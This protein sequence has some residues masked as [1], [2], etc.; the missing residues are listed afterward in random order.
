MINTLIIFKYSNS[1]NNL[2]FF[3]SKFYVKYHLINKFILIKNR[4]ILLDN[5]IQ[6]RK[7]KKKKL[8]LNLKQNPIFYKKKLLK[9][10]K[11]LS[12]N[13]YSRFKIPL[14]FKRSK[15][16]YLIKIILTN[17]HKV[18][19]LKKFLP[20]KNKNINL[21]YAPMRTNP[22]T[23]KSKPTANLI[24]TF[25]S[26]IK[27]M[28]FYRQ[29]YQDLLI[30]SRAHLHEKLKNKYIKKT[31]TSLYTKLK[32]TSVKP[33][34]IKRSKKFVKK[35]YKRSTNI[36]K[37]LKSGFKPMTSYLSFYFLNNFNS[38]FNINYFKYFGDTNT[39]TL[40]RYDYFDLYTEQ[41]FSLESYNKQIASLQNFHFKNNS[42]FFEN[43]NQNF[44]MH[45][46]HTELPHN[47]KYHKVT[48]LIN[49][50]KNYF[51]N[52]SNLVITNLYK[53]I[54]VTKESTNIPLNNFF[55]QLFTKTELH[56]VLN[57]EKLNIWSFMEKIIYSTMKIRI[58]YADKK[59]YYLFD[60]KSLHN[61]TPY[62]YNI[63]TQTSKLAIY[64]LTY[65][66]LT[67]CRNLNYYKNLKLFYK[68]LILIN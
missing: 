40:D 16:K 33:K 23:T 55:E 10:A 66:N 15:F 60:L 46:S 13:M 27:L 14:I 11:L 4:K 35:L 51:K 31:H 50:N 62:K 5:I 59:N 48:S 65:T 7:K 8:G 34:K 24:N 44:T 32:L 61:N 56:E 39:Q 30:K 49:I 43:F 21:F 54:K 64:L 57:E 22:N 20:I 12:F 58:L 3:F 38:L 9:Y 41:E 47:K 37:I 25:L 53:N 52:N 2:K 67:F 36:V 42:I 17:L 28:M 63:N 29:N 6:L 19:L 1:N 45:N 18:S 26:D 68:F